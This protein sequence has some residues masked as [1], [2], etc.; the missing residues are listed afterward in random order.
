[1]TDY[2][3]TAER[4]LRDLGSLRLE[5]VTPETIERWKGTLTVSNRT[6][7]KYLVILHGICRHAMK[8]WGLPTNPVASHLRAS[9]ERLRA[10]R[11]VSGHLVRTADLAPEGLSSAQAAANCPDARRD[12]SGRSS[13]QHLVRGLYV[14]RG[15]L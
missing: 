8:V 15:S 4:V 13:R 12:V 6:V 2:R 3:H 5:D 11:D 7:G 14:C 9:R 1:V 10:F